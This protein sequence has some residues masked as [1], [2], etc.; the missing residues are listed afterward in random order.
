MNAFE[1]NNSLEH[2]EITIL[3]IVV[4][5]GKAVLKSK[6]TSVLGI[7]AMSC[8]RRLLV[9]VSISSD[10]SRK[11][12]VPFPNLQQGDRYYQNEKEQ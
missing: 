5:S 11:F 3:P 2:V 6:K 12:G 1:N 9:F 10:D 4:L 7:I 8:T